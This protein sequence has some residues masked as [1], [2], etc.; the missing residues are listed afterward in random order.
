MKMKKVFKLSAIILAALIVTLVSFGYWFFTLLDDG[1]RKGDM[2]LST[3]QELPYF[4]KYQGENRGKILAVVTSTAKMG[5]ED[6]KTGYE[7]TELARAYM[8]FLANGFEVDI[9]SPKGGR[10]SVIIDKEDMGAF[11][12]AFLNDTL[13][14][15]KAN[16]TIPI[17]KINAADYEAVFFAGGKGAMFDFPNNQSIQTIVREYIQSD[18]IV[19]AVCHGPAAFVNVKLDN[20]KYMVE[21]R[22]ISAFTNEEELFLIP[23]AKSV[24]PFLLQEKLE[25]NGAKF[26]T[27]PQYLKQV[28]MDGNLI[29]GQNPWSTWSMAEMMVAQ[30]GYVPI[31]RTPTAE[32]N[33]VDVLTTYEKNG[34]TMAKKEL[35]SMTAVEGKLIN[36]QLIGMHAIVAVMQW[37]IRKSADLISL[38]AAIKS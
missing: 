11:D 3:M 2:H 14:Q 1:I 20:D 12:Y 33:S 6:K 37:K 27:G 25:K 36:R 15:R 8:V 13:A 31:K 10:P 24:F 19:G 23:N 26:A 7:L 34:Y 18:K 38:L 21:S 28:S 30:L 35:L 5:E 22:R 16:A 17:D 4:S 9:A 32:E 29:T